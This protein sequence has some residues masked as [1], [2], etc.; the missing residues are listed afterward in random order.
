VRPGGYAVTAGT[1]E[2][3]RRKNVRNLFAIVALAVLLLLAFAVISGS[4]YG[5]GEVRGLAAL[6]LKECRG[7]P[8]FAM[9]IE[10][11]RD[12]EIWA[13][14]PPTGARDCRYLRCS[15]APRDGSE[16]V[17]TRGKGA[18]VLKLPLGAGP[19]SNRNYNAYCGAESAATDQEGTPLRCPLAAAV[20]AHVGTTPV[21]CSPSLG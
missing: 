9:R 21:A 12:M 13:V 8:L 6:V 2:K 3:R 20:E 5:P 18:S 15:P 14:A 7:T 4:R 16:A 1:G 11:L 10:P 19:F 17:A